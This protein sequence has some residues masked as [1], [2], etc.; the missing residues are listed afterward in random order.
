MP[1]QHG[2]TRNLTN[3]SGV[4]ER[5]PQWSPDG[6]SIA[7]I[8][9]ASGEDEIYVMPQDGSTPPRQLTT[10]GDTY[11]YALEW[12][13]DSKKIC[14]N[15]RKQRLQYVEVATHAVK[16]VA[17]SK[18][19]EI[20]A[21]TWSP[22]SRW[23]AYAAPQSN[24]L[25]KVYLYSVEKQQA[26]E[27]TDDWY[28]AGSPAFSSDGKFLFV[29]SNRDFHPTYSRTEWNHAYQDMDRI[30]L[31]TL[32]KDTPSP[33]KPKSDEVSS[34]PKPEK[35]EEKPDEAK[36]EVVVRV[37]LDGLK[38]RIVDLPIQPSNYRSLTS[39]GGTLYYLRNGSRDPGPVLQM[40]DLASRKET[41]LGPVNG[42]EVTA[43]G[44][45]M[46]VARESNYYLVD[47][48]KAPLSLSEPLKLGGMEMRLDREKE[49]AQIFNECWRQMRDF[50]YAPNMHGVD[51]KAQRAKYEPLVH[52]VAHRADLTYIIGEMIAEL[53]VG[54]AYVGGGE[55]PHAERIQQGLLGAQL[56]R[57]PA[58]GFYQV[59]K[60]LRGLNWD[61]NLRS[62]LAELGVDVKEGEYITAVDGK[63]TN[64]MTNIYE[65]LVDTAGKQVSLK[66]NAEPKGQGG[67]TVVVVPTAS[68]ADL[69][70]YNWVQGNIKRVYEATGGKVG[71]V[72]IPDM[73]VTGLNEFMKHFYP[74][75][76]RKGLIIDVRGNGG[77]NVSPMLIE[78]LRREVVMI[79]IAR[80]GAPRVDPEATIY[81][82]KVCLMNEFS[83]SDGDLFP[84]RFKQSRL[85]PL[86]G[87]RSWGGVVGIRG[88]LPLLDGS[89]LNR[90]EF[91]RYDLAGKEWIIE[92]HGVDPD[93]VIDN[94]PAR[95]FAG[96]DQQLEKAIAVIKE[97]LKTHE[98]EIPPPPPYPKR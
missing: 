70:Y 2:P 7:F 71:Y 36:K 67:R 53:N 6:K 77:G 35:K 42:Y 47:L 13:P 31:I 58:T 17:E 57:D 89:F 76:Q 91:S 98:K 51:W 48:P 72:H 32:A 20:R 12:S 86:I 79:D 69:Y 60:I 85:G 93:I 22:D 52:H 29:V 37:D 94:D 66:I 92:G 84:Y 74:Q 73:Q 44:K 3:T 1:A 96:E 28:S 83:A 23:I 18:V 25:S 41:S 50:F 59:V 75:L 62:P 19:F 49:W 95:E 9:D 87:K 15:D 5:N 16:P 88:T 26:Y 8:S 33:F 43:N 90:P 27:A 14:W 30:Y 63:P 61:K 68:E 38:D 54:H 82:P 4:H 80:N 46:L 21:F 97:E 55:M 45:K 78:R 24:Q 39:E 10:G 34:E 65:A 56:R 40:F 64:E 11:K 81:G